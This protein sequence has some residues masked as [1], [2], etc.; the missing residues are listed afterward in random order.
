MR[1]S[2]LIY[3]AAGFPKIECI[4]NINE[5]C[6]I[7]G[8]NLNEGVHVKNIIGQK[9]TNFDICK[10]KESKYVCKECSYCM[11][12]AKIR[13]SNFIACE[14]KIIY[15]KKNDLEEYLFNLDKF[16]TVP[17]VVGLTRSFK[18]HNFFRCRVNYD[19]N[20]FYIRE[21]EKEYLFNVNEMKILY[22]KLNEA[23]LQFS[24]EELQ[25]GNYNVFGIENFGIDKFN[26]YESV[27]KE[28]RGTHQ[29]SLLLYIL[30]SEKR[31]EYIKEQLKLKKERQKLEKK[32]RGESNV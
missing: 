15:L 29:F 8:T 4:E 10:N 9:F 23:Y 25:S 27:F 32:K 26:E 20:T 1:N 3:K 7:C 17:F 28:F 6:F 22:E 18:K 12:E 2:E 19:L 16:I 24:K 14:S 21:E 11:K 31:N 13:R 5:K 30:N